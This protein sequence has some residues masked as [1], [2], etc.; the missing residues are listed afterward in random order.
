MTLLQGFAV[1]PVRPY[2]CEGSTASPCVWA[3]GIKG[4]YGRSLVD[5]IKP[6]IH[7]MNPVD[8]G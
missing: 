2:R 7:F 5:I 8:Q 1:R 6:V 3:R 4:Y